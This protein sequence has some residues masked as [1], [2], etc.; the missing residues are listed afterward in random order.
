MRAPELQFSGLPAGGGTNAGSIPAV[1]NCKVPCS[2]GCRVPAYIAWYPLC[3]ATA[4][5]LRKANDPNVPKS[6]MEELEEEAVR[7]YGYRGAKYIS[8]ASAQSSP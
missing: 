2:F 1:G 3:R 4:S 8:S 5:H 7:L 6:L